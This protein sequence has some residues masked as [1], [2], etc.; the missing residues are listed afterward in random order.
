MYSRYDSSSLEFTGNAQR[1]TTEI[2]RCLSSNLPELENYKVT[3]GYNLSRVHL[4]RKPAGT[5]NVF[6]DVIAPDSYT[7]DFWKGI[8]KTYRELE[9][10]LKVIGGATNIMFLEDP[11]DG[12]LIRNRHQPRFSD[13]SISNGTLKVSSGVSLEKLVLN[14]AKLGYDLSF[15]AG[16]PGTVGGAVAGNAGQSHTGL[17]I[18][19]IV[20]S[21]TFFDLNTGKLEELKINDQNFSNIFSQRHSIFTDI[22]SNSTLSVIIE[23]TLRPDHI[24]TEDAEQKLCHIL[25]QRADKNKIIYNTGCAGSFWV[26]LTTPPP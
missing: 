19:D 16:I 6:I 22:N 18:G 8:S 26:N 10:P 17:N 20:S 2:T 25:G 13:F 24:G 14:S 3:L 1:S 5:A 21:I 7:I 4:Y 11:I 9:L 15:M 23:V 12:L